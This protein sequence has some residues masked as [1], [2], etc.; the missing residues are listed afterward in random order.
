MK[1]RII[2]DEY[3]LLSAFEGLKAD[4]ITWATSIL[5]TGENTHQ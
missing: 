1:Q 4:E 2:W 3:I 5:T